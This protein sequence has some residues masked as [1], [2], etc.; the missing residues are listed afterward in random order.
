MNAAI[1]IIH[2]VT[3][4]VV[5]IVDENIHTVCPKLEGTEHETRSK[6]RTFFIVFYVDDIPYMERFAKAFRHAIALCGGKLSVF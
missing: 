5:S 6:G 3:T 1:N 4:L 2:A